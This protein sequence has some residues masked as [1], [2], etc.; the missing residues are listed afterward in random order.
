M[1][2]LKKI[3]R[4]TLPLTE[5][6]KIILALNK[7]NSAN[8]AAKD[9]LAWLGLGWAGLGGVDTREQEQGWVVHSDA[10]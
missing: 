1:E 9:G 4:G 6:T 8:Y 3:K 5:T 7:V 10:C 2:G